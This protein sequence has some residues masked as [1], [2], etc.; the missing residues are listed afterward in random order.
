MVEK[1]LIKRQH[2]SQK[3]DYNNLLPGYEYKLQLPNKVGKLKSS[4]SFHNRKTKLS[5]AIAVQ[6]TCYLVQVPQNL[7]GIAQ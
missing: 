1:C 3:S 7:L 4:E 2:L 6:Q 5:N